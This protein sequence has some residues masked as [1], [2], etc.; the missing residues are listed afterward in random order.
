MSRGALPRPDRPPE[1]VRRDVPHGLVLRPGHRRA[2]AADTAFLIPSAGRLAARYAE[3]TMPV[4]IVAGTDDEV[5]FF[6]SHARRLHGALP[7]SRLIGVPGAGHMIH[8][9]ALDVVARAI[10]SAGAPA[11]GAA[12]SRAAAPHQAR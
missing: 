5:V 10:E 7:G 11:R 8:H 4:T 2:T 6:D 9:S 1:R 12:P 3:L